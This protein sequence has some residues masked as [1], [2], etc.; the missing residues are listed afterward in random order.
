MSQ[1]VVTVARPAGASGQLQNPDIR[2]T[3]EGLQ[4]SVSGNGRIPAVMPPTAPQ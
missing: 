4:G 2:L 1:F 3:R